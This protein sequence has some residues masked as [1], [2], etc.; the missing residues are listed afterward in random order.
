MFCSNQKFVINGDT[1]EN[2]ITALN[3]IFSF[4]DTKK[5]EQMKV[6]DDGSYIVFTKYDNQKEG[7]QH[8]PIYGDVEMVA[9]IIQT[10]LKSKDAEPHF[11]S[12]YEGGDGSYYNGWEI[13][14]AEDYN[15]RGNHFYVRP[16]RTYYSK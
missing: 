7:F 3:C 4:M 8:I 10:Y 14:L 15:I 2:L 6:A 11:H 16:Y 12:D 9:Q 5:M 1:K 13:F